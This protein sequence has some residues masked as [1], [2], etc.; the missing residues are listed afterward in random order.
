MDDSRSPKTGHPIG[1]HRSL[2]EL[3]LISRWSPLPERARVT[4][5]PWTSRKRGIIPPLA[6]PALPIAHRS[7]SASG[8]GAQKLGCLKSAARGKRRPPCSHFLRP[9]LQERQDEV[10]S[11]IEKAQIELAGDRALSPIFGC[12]FPT[13]EEE[14]SRTRPWIWSIYYKYV[15]VL[16]RSGMTCLV[17]PCPTTWEQH[18]F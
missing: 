17:T 9:R 6:P 10:R 15:Y 2:S 14:A 7:S 4:S 11:E 8:S 3:R 12:T 5:Q 13:L 16:P 1:V 18:C